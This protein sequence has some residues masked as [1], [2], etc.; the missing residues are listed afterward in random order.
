MGG[1]FGIGAQPAPTPSPVAA[2]AALAPT[3][4]AATRTD[5]ATT[6]LADMQRQKYMGAKRRS[7][8]DTLSGGGRNT[9]GM[10]SSLQTLGGGTPS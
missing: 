2:A 9:L 7:T 10:I 5:A 1:L 8:L 6:A 3:D 4:P